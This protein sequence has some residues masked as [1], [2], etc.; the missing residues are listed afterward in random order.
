MMNDG[1]AHFSDDRKYRYLLG[2]RI[3]DS[4]RRLLFVMLNPSTADAHKSDNT[5]TRCENFARDWGF[6]TMEVVNLFAFKSTDPAGLR[7]E[8]KPAGSRNNAYI[9]DAVS[10]ADRVVLAWSGEVAKSPGFKKRAARVMKMVL[11][12]TRPYHLGLTQNGEPKHPS[13][14]PNGAV[15]IRW[16]TSQIAE[17]IR[18]HNSQL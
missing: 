4:P 6:G 15:P 8:K 16:T 14:L 3:S 10:T 13:R 5:I 7:D 18:T 11:K 2:R 1:W 17:Y 12:V 9:R